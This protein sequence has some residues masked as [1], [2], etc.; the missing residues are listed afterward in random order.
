MSVFKTQ[1]W[2]DAV[3][4]VNYD[5]NLVPEREIPSVLTKA[6]G[7]KVANAWEWMSVR[8]PE[9]LDFYTREVYGEFPPRPEE[10][11]S[12][13]VNVKNDAL[14]NTAIRKE[15]KVTFRQG[16]LSH[17]LMMLVY[18]PKEAP[19]KVPVFLGL[20]FKGN[21]AT[22]DETDVLE[23]GRDTDG[24]LVELARGVQCERWEFKKAVARGFAVA[25]CCYH[26][27]F[28]DFP[29]DEAWRQSIYRIFYPEMIPAELN[30]KHSAIG[31]WA[32]GLSRM[33]DVLEGEKLIDCRRAGVCGHSRLGKTSLWCGA[34]DLRF[35]VVASNDSG[36]GGSALFKRNLGESITILNM[37]FPHWFVSGFEQY[38]DKDAD[39]PFD[40]NFLMA[41][42]APRMLCIGSATEDLWADPKGEF[43][44]GVYA[45][46]VYR[47]FG[48]PGMPVT[49]HPAADVN[50]TG[51]ISYHMRTGV[52]N[53]LWQDWDHYFEAAEKFFGI[54]PDR[55]I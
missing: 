33:L 47:L 28:P 3:D 6:D 49:E 51:E 43:L 39:L 24:N 36:H 30:K 4:K 25:T 11:T 48:V 15:I 34:N 23:T 18:I 35:Q 31:A 26:D 20:N 27:I 9:V 7:S 22:T 53:I 29:T 50:V 5:E 44:A 45:S 2:K 40:Q 54:K 38:N 16:D 10:M 37:A 21:H 13:I 52:H 14:D 46:E 8:R 19:E 55:C 41:L 17:S 1:A 12:E 42:I 32:W